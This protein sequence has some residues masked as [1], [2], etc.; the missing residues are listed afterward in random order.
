[1]D[2]LGNT[3]KICFIILAHHRYH[4]F[5]FVRNDDSGQSHSLLFLSKTPLVDILIWTRNSSLV[6]HHAYDKAIGSHPQAL[7]N[8]FRIHSRPQES[9]LSGWFYPSFSK[10]SSDMPTILWTV[11]IIIRMTPSTIP[12]DHCRT[13]GGFRTSS[14][15]TRGGNYISWSSGLYHKVCIRPK[16]FHFT[17]LETSLYDRLL[18]TVR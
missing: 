18:N 2:G 9:S 15:R 16:T 14:P 6:I 8:T 5:S 10:A 1:M 4:E 17:A 3:D 11:I 13:V 12:W 7:R